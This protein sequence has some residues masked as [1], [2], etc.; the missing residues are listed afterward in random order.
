MKSPK[1]LYKDEKGLALLST[2]IQ[3][4]VRIVLGETGVIAMIGSWV[5]G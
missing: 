2:T 1:E 3:I 5:G 4:L